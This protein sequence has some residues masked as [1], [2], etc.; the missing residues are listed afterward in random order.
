MEGTMRRM[1]L[2]VAALGLG[3]CNPDPQTLTALILRPTLN[4][5]KS[6][7]GK[8]GFVPASPQIGIMSDA[9]GG[10][11]WIADL[12]PLGIGA[13]RFGDPRVCRS[14]GQCNDRLD[15]SQ[16]AADWHGYL[17]SENA[18]SAGTT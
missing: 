8:F 18:R 15:A 12:T 11:C 14:D 16:K 9:L 10:A 1:V 7:S 13:P 5:D 4:P 17:S 6:L 2:L 3:S